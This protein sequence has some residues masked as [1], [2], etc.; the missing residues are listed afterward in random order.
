MKILRAFKSEHDRDDMAYCG[1]SP[2]MRE[3]TKLYDVTQIV[4]KSDYKEEDY[5]NIIR[6][7]DVL[8]TMWGSPHVPNELAENPGNLKYI[9]NV[10]GE[11]SKWIDEDIVASPYITVTNWGDAAG[12]GVAEGAVSLMMTMLKDIPVFIDYMKKGKDR[13]EKSSL[14]IGT[15]YH[16]KVGIYGMGFI[17]RKF[18]EYIKPFMPYIY[19]FDP[20]VDNMPEGVT[21]VNSL[22]EL[23]STAQIMVIHAGWTPETEKT[24]TKE[25]L[26]MLPDG[27]VFINT[28]RG[29]IVDEPALMEEIMSGRIRA[30]LDVLDQRL[31]PPGNGDM[32]LVESPVRQV[33]NAVFTGHHICG[34]EWSADPE[35]LDFVSINALDN[36][37][38]YTNGEPLRFIIDVDRYRKMT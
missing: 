12:Y 24:V 9:C 23:F 4:L 11:I 5:A 16:T 25:L 13:P 20:Y 10:T 30:G 33:S 36:L 31:A 6:E 32:P 19:A 8:I 18:V 14:R 2:F 22:E 17:G 38:R 1:R 28:A 3:L 35:K 29:P 34:D 26:A 15:L 7:Y 27:A 21:K 37:K